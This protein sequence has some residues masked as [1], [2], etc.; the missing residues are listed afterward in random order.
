MRASRSRCPKPAELPPRLE[1]VLEAIYAAYGSGWDDVAAAIRIARGC[2]SRRSAIGRTLVELLPDEPEAHGLLALMLHCEAR[3]EARRER[4][5]RLCAAAEQDVARWS[6]P[7]IAEAERVARARRRRPAA[8]DRFQLEA[9]IQSVHAQRAVTGTNRLGGDSVALRRPRPAGARRSARWSAAP[10]RLPRRAAP[11]PALA[12]WQNCRRTRSQPTSR[13]GR[14][15][16]ICLQARL[17]RRRGA[18]SVRAG[19]R[20][21]RATTRCAGS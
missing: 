6:Q 14:W 7:M 5:R 18:R 1:A 16:R 2:R 12:C 17:Q 9:A 21:V 15:S 10:R 4:S 11:R 13:S 8:S 3:R 19:D 20:P